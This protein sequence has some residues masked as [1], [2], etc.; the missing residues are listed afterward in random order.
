MVPDPLDGAGPNQIPAHGHATDHQE[1]AEMEGVWEMVISSAGG[2][3]GGGGLQGYRG[4]HH[5]EVE[6]GRAIYCDANDSG[7]L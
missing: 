6:Y 3:D 7:P 5:E 4:L 2:S 1:A